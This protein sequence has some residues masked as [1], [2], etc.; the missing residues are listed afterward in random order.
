[1]LKTNHG[2]LLLIESSVVSPYQVY[3]CAAST[4]LSKPLNVT[5]KKPF[6]PAQVEPKGMD[7]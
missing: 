3:A 1:L 2:E 4:G 7:H 5:Y 6:G